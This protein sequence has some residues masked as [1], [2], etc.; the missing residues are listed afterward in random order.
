[1]HTVTLEQSCDLNNKILYLDM[2]LY[3]SFGALLDDE[4]K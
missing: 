3:F 4:V 2:G 1:M